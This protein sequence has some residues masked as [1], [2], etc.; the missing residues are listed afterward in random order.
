M[1]RPRKCILVIL[2]LLLAA[3]G[4]IVATVY[5][6]TFTPQGRL[7]PEIAIARQMMMRQPPPGTVPVEETRR[8]FSRSARW[9]LMG[10]HIPL[11]SVQDHAVKA[12][13]RAIPVR[14]YRPVP[15]TDL[16]LLVYCHGGGF[17][18][19]GLDTHDSICRRLA[20]DA[21][22]VV[23]SVDYRLAPEHRFPA[24][25]DDVYEALLWAAGHARQLGA[26]SDRIAVGG[27]SAGANLAAVTALRAR[28]R[29]EVSLAFQLLIYP[30]VDMTDHQTQSWKDLDGFLLSRAT[31]DFF[32]SGYLPDPELYGH[33]YASPLLA[34]DHSRLPPALVITAE[35]DP[36]RDEGEAYARKLVTA[37]V[38][39]RF[40]RYSG[41]VHG[42]FGLRPCRKSEQAFDEVTKAL[43]E[44][45]G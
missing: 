23:V 36:L 10:G 14:V 8:L 38:P 16:P 4:L 18:A 33:P 11:H 13:D 3:L 45:L 32:R 24:A 28:D 30:R 1:G 19:G 21:R 29:G 12:D 35:F 15:E 34:P 26:R 2:T 31:A 20:R 42:F 40:V 5:S 27:D 6:W 22:V 7:D 25:P 39:A 17:S 44:A 37:G 43:R 41:V 9:G